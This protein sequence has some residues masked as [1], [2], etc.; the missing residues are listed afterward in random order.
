MDP[1]STKLS[2]NNRTRT[3]MGPL[4][5]HLTNCYNVNCILVCGAYSG[6]NR[7]LDIEA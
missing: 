6:N 4:D 7:S 1:N 5:L 3:E 2:A